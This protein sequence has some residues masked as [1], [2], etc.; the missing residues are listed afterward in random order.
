M[1]EKFTMDV[2]PRTLF[3]AIEETDENLY[4]TFPDVNKKEIAMDKNTNAYVLP[5]SD[6]ENGGALIRFA[7]MSVITDG[8]VAHEC[9]HAIM[10]FCNY[11]GM[12]VDTSSTNEH[13][14]YMIEWA[15]DRVSET[16][17]KYALEQRMEGGV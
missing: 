3:V 5:V 8:M 17:R 2:F 4:K 15:A 10:Y 9:F 11:L 14:A 13:I 1:I 12:D 7:S 6:G 16:K